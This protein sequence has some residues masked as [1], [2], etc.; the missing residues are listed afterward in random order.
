[1]YRKPRAA[2]VTA[3][4]DGV[5]WAMDRR[6]FRSI[7]MKSA[8]ADVI[9]VLRSVEVLKSLS[10]GQLQRLADV[11]TEVEFQHGEYVV[12]QG[13]DS[14]TFYVIAEGKANCTRNLTNAK[15]EKTGEEPLMTLETSNYFGERALLKHEPR[16]ANVIAEQ[17][18]KCLQISK[19]GFEEVLGSL[20]AI[21]DD[22]RKWRE[23]I[24]QSKQLLQ[25]A[26]GLLNEDFS[27]FTVQ[28]QVF[29]SDMFTMVLAEHNS[30]TYTIKALSKAKVVERHMQAAVMNEKALLSQIT[31]ANRFVPL[32][33]STMND[34]NYLYTVF[35]VRVAMELSA[36]MEEQPLS[37]ATAKFYGASLSCAIAYLHQEG[38]MYRNLAPDNLVLDSAGYVQLMDFRNAAKIEKFAPQRDYCGVA[39]YL[40]PEQ[41]SGQGHSKEVD[42]WALG[43]LLFEMVC[44]QAPWLTGDD[45]KDTELSIYAKISAH[46]SG[47]LELPEQSSF[48]VNFVNDLLE[49]QPDKRLGARGVGPEEL[50]ATDWFRGYDWGKIQAGLT[51]SPHVDAAARASATEVAPAELSD[52]YTGDKEWCEGFSAFITPRN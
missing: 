32:A 20:Q 36:I 31:N 21:I 10:V 22:D 3:L 2:T 28:G 19:D 7:L 40:A 49:P 15:G 35:K 6:S 48:M 38:I 42:Y 18:L 46:T 24:A 16:A 14:S 52:V 43:I 37:E 9:R 26:E 44:G 12:Q 50:R 47:S 41:V 17:K 27:T 25:E 30:K 1:M 5:L 39:H 11:L 29:S 8:T 33:L 4:K 51:K 45:L 23:R 13:D 34:P